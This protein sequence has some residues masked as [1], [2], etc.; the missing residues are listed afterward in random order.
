ML[1]RFTFI[2]LLSHFSHNG[3]TVVG[4]ITA[5]RR[6]TYFAD[7]IA[8]LCFKSTGEHY[9]YSSISF[10]FLSKI[11]GSKFIPVFLNRVMNVLSC[12][13]SSAF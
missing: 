5:A 13:Y 4:K 1:G 2:Y 6:S 10:A 8:S 7:A 3:F 12:P 9:H 11:V